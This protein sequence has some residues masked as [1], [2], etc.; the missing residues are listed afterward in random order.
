VTGAVLPLTA[1]GDLDVVATDSRASALLA[2]SGDEGERDGTGAA[3][4]HLLADTLTA[5]LQDPGVPRSMAVAPPRGTALPPDLL[6][7]LSDGVGGA[8][9][10][11]PA[12]IALPPSTTGTAPPATLTGRGPDAVELGGLTAYLDPGVSPL[13]AAALRSLAS[14]R[15]T[16]DGLRE[17][18][19][20]TTAVDTW[21]RSLRHAWSTRW[22]E[23]PQAWEGSWRPVRAASV[24]ARAA[25]HV[26]PGTVNFLADQGLMRVTIVNT[27]PVAV[28]DVRVRLVSSSS[29]LQVVDQP[30]PISIGP[31]SRATVSFSARAVTRG[32]TTVTA[33]LTAPNGTSLG[34]N[35]PVEVRVQPTGVWIY[36]V[37]GGVA[38]VVLALGLG[39]ALRSTPR[40]VLAG[41]RAPSRGAD[42]DPA[43][44][45]PAPT[46]PT[47][48]A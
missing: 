41:T 32:E 9:W 29:I 10:L 22:R 6:A 12:P 16:L 46:T 37:L 36:W 27:L 28:E 19:V 34:D 8:P 26:N 40:A 31:D 35:A 25:L 15:G 20:G 11:A 14:L 23:D 24:E 43:G 4:Q 45:A 18:L 30:D 48:P 3:V 1:P 33:Q 39:R 17:V 13:D 44:G 21:E 7:E 5:W 2:G 38:G 42:G 47:G